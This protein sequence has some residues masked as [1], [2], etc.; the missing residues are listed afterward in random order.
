MVYSYKIRI[1]KFVNQKLYTVFC[2]N[3]CYQIL[4]TKHKTFMPFRKINKHIDTFGFWLF[5]FGLTLFFSCGNKTPDTQ[6]IYIDE[7]KLKKRIE[8]VQKP[9][10]VMENDQ[11]NDYIRQHGLN[12]QTSG[13][14]LRYQILKGNPKGK[15][16]QT[17]DIV[18][19][20]YKISLLDGT[21]CYSSDKKG[22]K[23]FIVDHDAVET[24]LHQG[25]KLLHEGESA[26]FILPSHLAHGLVG[27][28]NKIPPKAAVVYTIE[29]ID[30]KTKKSL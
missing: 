15:I 7:N 26:V 27:D 20:K 2:L 21:L 23:E 16:I 10:L 12:M 4:A 13:A 19:V 30:V 6:K 17:Q 3:T 22:P 11:I 18:Q 5:T 8:E 14:G 24:G 28:N 9:A 1:R 29:V 25:I